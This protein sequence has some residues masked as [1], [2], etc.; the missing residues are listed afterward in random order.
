MLRQITKK[1]ILA[2]LG[3]IDKDITFDVTL[4][5]LG[6]TALT[7]LGNKILTFAQNS[8]RNTQNS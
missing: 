5:S 2:L 8:Y 3:L 7:L 1:H 6:G 4:V